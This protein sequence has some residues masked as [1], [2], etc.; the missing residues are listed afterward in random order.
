MRFSNP[1]L[2]E[3]EIVIPQSNLAFP[4]C[5]TLNL[6]MDANGHRHLWWK[7]RIVNLPDGKQE[8]HWLRCLL[9]GLSSDLLVAC[10]PPIVKI[11]VFD[12][13]GLLSTSVS[14]H[15]LAEPI[16]ENQ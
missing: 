11:E 1:T 13:Q 10:V 15:D 7:Y 2:A 8:V 12:K 4:L 5:P 6:R 9:T 16:Q 14:V 3:L